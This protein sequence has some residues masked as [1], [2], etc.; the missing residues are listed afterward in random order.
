MIPV[1]LIIMTKNEERNIEKCLRSVSMF[2][3]IFVVDSGSEDRTC[4]IA[5][6]WDAS[7]VQFKWN[8][9]YPKKKQW[10]LENLPFK[11]DWVFY[12]DAD[13]EIY[14]ELA[15]EI[16]DLMAGGPKHSGYFVSYDYLFLGSVLKHGHRIYKLVLF[17]RHKGRFLE[18]EDLNV[19]NMW[20]VEGHYQPKIQGSTGILKN[21]MLHNDHDSL[22]Q[23]FERH[24]RYSD[25]EA[26]LRGKNVLLSPEETLPGVRKLMKKI[27]DKL[28]FRALIAF[29]HCYCL[30]LGFLDG[31]P[32]FHF[33][34]ARAFYYWQIAVK[35][36]NLKKNTIET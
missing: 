5:E 22:F 15:D 32:G 7:I 23:Y 16:F 12:V 19:S 11:Y 4:E 2:D 28:P 36:H 27:F 18:Y 21:R 34:L 25:W 17:D 6:D 14:P 26:S 20:E 8:G 1:S 24:N 35:T 10:C 29:F 9:R 33:A 30:K 3:Q 31:L 13:E